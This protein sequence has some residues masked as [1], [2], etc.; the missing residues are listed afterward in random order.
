[1]P[2]LHHGRDP[3][4]RRSQRMRDLRSRMEKPSYRGKLCPKS[5]ICEKGSIRRRDIPVPHFSPFKTPTASSSSHDSVCRKPACT[6]PSRWAHKSHTPRWCRFSHAI[7]SPPDAGLEV[8]WKCLP[9]CTTALPPTRSHFSARFSIP[10][11]RPDASSR[12]TRGKTQP[13]DPDPLIEV[14]YFFYKV[15]SQLAQH[16][17]VCL[18]SHI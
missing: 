8:A 3:R 7:K 9:A 17:T 10:V 14:S 15:K 12:K 6:D 1:M 11:A 16:I 13:P 2:A 18:Y 5:D 4:P